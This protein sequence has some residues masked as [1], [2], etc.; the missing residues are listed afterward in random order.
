MTRFPGMSIMSNPRTTL[1]L[2]IRFLVR[3][4]SAILA[5]VVLLTATGGGADDRAVDQGNSGA[6]EKKEDADDAKLKRL[7]AFYAEQARQQVFYR[8]AEHTQ[9]LV[10]EPKPVYSF[11]GTEGGG[12]STFVWTWQGRPQIVGAITF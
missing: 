11:G 5:T 10:L 2:R 1:A 7:E 9:T 6:G 12:G 4:S 8:D 3:W